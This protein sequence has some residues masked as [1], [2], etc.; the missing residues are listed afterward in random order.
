MRNDPPASSGLWYPSGGTLRSCWF[1]FR[2][3]NSNEFERQLERA[4]GCAKEGRHN[5]RKKSDIE[6]CG[7]ILLLSLSLLVIDG[8]GGVEW[9]GV[10][11]DGMS[12]PARMV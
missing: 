3:H 7:D 4:E 5:E 1:S 11:W 12:L 8:K 9:S 2:A 6:I 10:G